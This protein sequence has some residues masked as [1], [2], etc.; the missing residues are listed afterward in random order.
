VRY[1]TDVTTLERVSWNSLTLP[2]VAVGDPY[3]DR[4]DLRIEC[5]K[6]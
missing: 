6:E 2:I 3:G 5:S 4:R 1:R